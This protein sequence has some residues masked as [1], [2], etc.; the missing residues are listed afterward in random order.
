MA[1]IVD[2]DRPDDTLM[3]VAAND[4]TNRCSTH[5]SAL[6]RGERCE[7]SFPLSAGARSKRSLGNPSKASST[8]LTV[9]SSEHVN[10]LLA[11][12]SNEVIGYSC[13]HSLVPNIYP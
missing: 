4:S 1:R 5:G 2:E 13:F 3:L 8:S 11:P 10:P 6:S 9:S 12:R 7:G